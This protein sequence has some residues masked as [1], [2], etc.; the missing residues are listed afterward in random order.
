LTDLEIQKHR[1]SD[2]PC[3]VIIERNEWEAL[4]CYHNKTKVPPKKPP[5]LMEA[6]K[7]VA[8]LGGFLNRKNEG[9]PGVKVIWRGMKK[10]YYVTETYIIFKRNVGNG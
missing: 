1:R 9:Y 8:V 4:Y 6:V 3:N 7:M 5:T 10:L 2:K